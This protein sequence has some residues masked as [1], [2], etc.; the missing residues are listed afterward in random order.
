MPNESNSLD[1]SLE[2]RKPQRQKHK[3][4]ATTFPKIWNDF[5]RFSWEDGEVA[6]GLL[7]L[8][9]MVGEGWIPSPEQIHILLSLLLHP[10]APNSNSISSTSSASSLTQASTPGS[11]LRLLRRILAV[12]GAEAILRAVPSYSA[13]EGEE[14]T[15][16][17]VLE[18]NVRC[19]LG[20]EDAKE[21]EELP[22]PFAA[23]KE[24]DISYFVVAD[25]SGPKTSATEGRGDDSD[26][27]DNVPAAPF[28]DRQLRSSLRPAAK[29]G[30]GR[31]VGKDK[32]SDDDEEVEKI[33]PLIK[34][35]WRIRDAENVWDILAGKA[36][37]AK[38]RREGVVIWNTP[39]DGREDGWKALEFFVE[40][41]EWD[42]GRAFKNGKGCPHFPSYD[43]TIGLTCG[44]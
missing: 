30:M 7:T 31:S 37:R 44:C 40:C 34:A 12:N 3:K 23:P 26:A 13:K 5:L 25:S 11:A 2:G 35:G 19:M 21:G 4:T 43:L 38:E 15:R 42:S 39:D 8:D 18:W 9:G 20:L 33:G 32:G 29:R 6:E 36:G 17:D 41:W 22:D 27:E 28:S 1:L 16:R 10:P 14:H 24:V